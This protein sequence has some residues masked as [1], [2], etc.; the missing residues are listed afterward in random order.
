MLNRM[1]FLTRLFKPADRLAPSLAVDLARLKKALS[2]LGVPKTELEL[3]ELSP[4]AQ[5]GEINKYF[6]NRLLRSTPQDRVAIAKV[7]SRADDR[8]PSTI[9][10]LGSS[11]NAIEAAPM[12][13]TGCTDLG[14]GFSAQQVNEIHHH[15]A[16]CPLLL[17]H[18]AHTAKQ[19]VASL[20]DVPEGQSYACYEYLDLWSSPHVIEL[21]A[22]D[23]T[24]DL[25]QQYLGCVPT[26]Y[27]INAFWSLP[28]RQ[29]HPYSQ[30]FHRDWEDYRSLVTFTQLTPVANPEDGAHYYV[31]GSHDDATFERM[32]QSR[33]VP[34]EDITKLSSRDGPAVATIAEPLFSQTARRFDGLAGRSFCSDGYGLHRAVVP[35]SQPRLLLWFR[36]GTFYN[37][38][39]YRGPLP[40]KDRNEAQ[41]IVRRIPDTPRHRYV[42]RYL[43]DALVNRTGS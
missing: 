28:N 8:L 32:L 19:R 37:S 43:I 13:A 18:D 3:R 38:T 7:M 30:L 11:S 24:L 31:E 16:G 39:M 34:R 2:L 27:S 21:A 12:C 41:A 4:A 5:L 22:S 23:R 10:N 36:F 1:T 42:F 20:A 40:P 15:L 17:A 6:G 33:A 9:R 14:A 25:A 35:R 29:P 26:I